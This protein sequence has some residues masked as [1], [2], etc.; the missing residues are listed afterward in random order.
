MADNT[1]R[2]YG[3]AIRLFRSWCADQRCDA[4]PATAE[5]V[6]EYIASLI[7][8]GKRGSSVKIH[9]CA[10]A[11]LHKSNGHCSPTDN[12]LVRAVLRGSMRLRGGLVDQKLPVVAAK[13]KDI[14][15]HIPGTLKGR[16]DRAMLAL[17]FAGALRRS[18]VAALR[19]ED[20][21][22][23]EQGATIIIRKSKTDIRGL[24]THIAVPNGPSLQA[25]SLLKDWLDAANITRGAVF[26]PVYR[27]RVLPRTVE[28]L[29]VSR[30]LKA[31]M[32]KAGFD[33]ARYGAHSLRAGF[34]T[35]AA[36]AGVSLDRIMDHSR[37]VE[38]RHVRAYVRR[39][40]LFQDHPGDAFL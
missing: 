12:Y 15:Q 6:A 36:E 25:V 31:Y 21:D 33:P 26:R 19:F 20:I 14:L 8:A 37:H 38:P 29:L 34:I 13:F 11:H 2:T 5:V 16:R 18:E 35:S 10:I 22:F 7:A 39:A 32:K 17:C 4:L 3:S 9:A 28:P 1:H 40:N 24:G 27:S 30:I 23:S